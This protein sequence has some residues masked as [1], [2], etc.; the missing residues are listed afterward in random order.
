MSPKSLKYSEIHPLYLSYRLP[1]AL[2]E[3]SLNGT[4]ILTVQFQHFKD[5]I[6]R[7]NFLEEETQDKKVT[8]KMSG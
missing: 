5:T 7:V 4:D 3:A 1:W 2:R 8:V 6:I